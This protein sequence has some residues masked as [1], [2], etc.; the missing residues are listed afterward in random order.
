VLDLDEATNNA[1][2]EIDLATLRGL[3][4]QA[5]VAHRVRRVGDRVGKGVGG[6]VEF[7]D[8]R[9]YAPGD[10]LRRV[11]WNAAART[12]RL[13]VKRHAHDSALPVH[14]GIDLSRSMGVG[15]PSALA[16]AQEVARGLAYVALS[17]GATVTVVGL[18]RSPVTVATVSRRGGLSAVETALRALHTHGDADVGRALRAYAGR[19]RDTGVFVLLT[20]ML[21]GAGARECLRSLRPFESSV[22][23]LI[24]AA[25]F[26]DPTSGPLRVQDAETGAERDLVWDDSA[27]SAYARRRDELLRHMPSLAAGL[28]IRYA[29]V[30]TDRVGPD[31]FLKE[32]RNAGIVG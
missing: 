28:G 26:A 8:H 13:V 17:G 21:D 3:R 27:A 25:L 11:D 7:V 31:V 29:S 18:A 16:I 19:A 23:H 9:P 20:D 12:D 5:H 2:R 6:R 30:R 15:D 10:D 22:V 14:L 1:L 32:F 24:S 4:L